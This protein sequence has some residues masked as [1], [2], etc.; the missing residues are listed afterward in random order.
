M[1]VRFT[2]EEMEYLDRCA[3][4]QTKH[5]DESVNFSQYVRERLLEGTPPGS[6]EENLRQ[7]RSL[8][9]TV[10]RIGTNINRITKKINTGYLGGMEDIIELKEELA[11]IEACLLETKEG[12]ER[13]G[14]R[15]GGEG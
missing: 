1:S 8:V 11:R 9:E 4:S 5:K 13:S 15:S 10:H 12:I 14:D 3:S 6:R 7:I 2:P